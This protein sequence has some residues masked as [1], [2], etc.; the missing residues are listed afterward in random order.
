MATVKKRKLARF[1]HVTRGHDSLPKT[2]SQ[3]PLEVGRRRVCQRKDNIEEWA[4]LPVPELL[5]MAFCG[6]DWK[7][8]SAESSVISPR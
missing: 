4:Y 6:K 8:I 1:G 2:I 7:K 5:T 3:G